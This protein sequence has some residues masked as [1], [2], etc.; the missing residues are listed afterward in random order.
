MGVGF[1]KDGSSASGRDLNTLRYHLA[2]AYV[3]NISK[4]SKICQQESITF[5]VLFNLFFKYII[6]CSPISSFCMFPSY[7]FL[8]STSTHCSI[9]ELKF[10]ESSEVWRGGQKNQ[11][12]TTVPQKSSQ[13]CYNF[14]KYKKIWK[15]MKYF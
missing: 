12:H 15:G 4:T 9:A 6:F 1:Y 11:K 14:Q 10:L 7:T 2:C 5:N 13:I 3:C 8:K